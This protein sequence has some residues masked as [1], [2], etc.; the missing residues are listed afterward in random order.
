MKR[1]NFSEQ[2]F[3]FI[4]TRYIVVKSNWIHKYVIQLIYI[5]ITRLFKRCFTNNLLIIFNFKTRNCPV[6]RL[7]HD[8][9][10]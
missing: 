3:F 1:D 4:I 8:Y 6:A 9:K 5:K 2:L 7:A 10:I